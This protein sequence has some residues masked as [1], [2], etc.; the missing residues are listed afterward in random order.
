MT[1]GLGPFGFGCAG[2]AGMY[3]ACPERKAMATLQAAW[4][5]GIRY[6][7]TAPFYGTGLS[8]QRLGQFLQGKRATVSTK[9]GRVLTPVDDAPDNGFI[10]ALPALVHFDYTHDAILRSFEASLARLDH[11]DILYVHDIGRFAHGDQAD[12][13]MADLMGSGLQALMRLRD[14]GAISA[15]G[16]GINEA[17]VCVQVMQVA[18]P[19][20]ILLAGRYTLLDQRAESLLPLC[21]AR[22]VPL[23]IGGVVNSGILATGAVPG[24]HF[25]YE[26]A[27]ADILSRVRGI[28][29]LC[30]GEG[31]SL[32]AA[33]L[34][35]PGR[36]TAVASVLL[37]N[38]DPAG[39]L[40]N[41]NA[42]RQP[43]PDRLFQAAAH[44]ALREN[45]P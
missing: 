15:W 6:F 20:V 21:Q 41:L 42:V 22:G 13:H 34:Q 10:G 8:E 39:L 7:D 2:I 18:Q 4:D 35:F 40:Q 1:S 44:Y 29:A 36:S 11:I 5:S 30:K 33:A 25:N 23:V 17:E 43:V 14:E 9:V 31:V 32:L 37:G 12:R 45:S 26:P 27:S 16:L 24:A 3:Q 38:A 28:E 19:D